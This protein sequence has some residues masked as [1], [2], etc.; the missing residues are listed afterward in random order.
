MK[1]VTVIFLT[2]ALLTCASGAISADRALGKLSSL[3]PH[4]K[5]VTD[6]GREA[7][8]TE[9]S[10]VIGLALR[11]RDNLEQFLVDVQNPA[12]PLY[13]QFLTP[14]QFNA[15]YAPTPAEEERVVG[16]LQAN[17]LKVTDRFPNRLLVGAVG[18]VA[19]LE[20]AFGVEMHRV[21]FKG[22]SHYAALNEPSLPPDIAPSVVGVLGLDDLTAMHPH[23]RASKPVQE[24][25]AALGSNCCHLSPNDLATFYDDTTIY[26]G[27]G[28]T[29]IIA[30]AYAW[31]DSDI[32]TFNTRWG[33]PP[34]PAGSMQVCTGS[35]R[36]SGCKFHPQNS[37]EIALDVEYAHGT[38]P[39]AKI[40]NYMAASTSF[41]DFA[42]MYNRIVTDNLGHVVS[43]SWGACEA[44][45]STA[46]QQTNDNI[47]ANVNTIGQSWFAASGDNGSR[48]CSGILT[49]DHPANS[50][51]VIAVGGTTPVCSSGMTASNP[52]CGGYGA[53]SGWSGSGG[54]IS[55]VFARPA[56]Q[57][58]CG[59]PTGSQRLV[60]DVALEADP[61]PGNYVAE[62]GFWYIVG[63]TSDAAPQWAGFF[64]ELN[65]EKGG[66]GLGHPGTRLY[67]LCSGTLSPVYH[68][69][70]AGSNG[71]YGAGAGYDMVTGL[72]STDA[73]NLLTLY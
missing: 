14:E 54:G 44:G 56:F 41:A 39:S 36:S 69:I 26:Y 66:T 72:G 28:Q 34:L 67:Q 48:D 13:H 1:T 10:I 31:K 20:R 37:I 65:Q 51:H 40:L 35:S 11:N 23:V 58:G 60:P 8:T 18:S 32:T 61:S 25:H 50:P 3:S 62:N 19:A 53:E 4:L 24:P 64:A 7:P 45:V 73:K 27:T 55:Q 29:L 12:S 17:G 49:V 71:D 52:A 42:R 16:Y 43:T 46:T 57:T 6:L 22:E 59:V 68:D 63:G 2:G 30:G 47:F 21:A 70:T 33:L 38:A 9:H 5:Q 15:L